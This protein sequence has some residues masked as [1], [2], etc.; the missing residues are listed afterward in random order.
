MQI[1]SDTFELGNLWEEDEKISPLTGPLALRYHVPFSCLL[2]CYLVLRLRLRWRRRATSTNALFGF[3]HV[4][5]IT[6]HLLFA[7]GIVRVMAS[8]AFA[9]WSDHALST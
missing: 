6:S 8:W 2:R 9:F 7:N 4:A 5:V 3:F 1:D